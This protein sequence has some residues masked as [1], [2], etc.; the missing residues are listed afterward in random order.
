MMAEDGRN[1]GGQRGLDSQDTLID[2]PAPPEEHGG[3]SPERPGWF[4]SQRIVVTPTLILLNIAVFALMVVR[5]VALVEPA[6]SDVLPFGANFGPASLS[7]EPWR[8]LTAAFVHGGVVPFL[9]NVFCVL[10]VGW[11]TETLFG[12]AALAAIYLLSVLG[13]SLASLFW[14]PLAIAAGASGA[15]GGLWGALQAVAVVRYRQFPSRIVLAISALSAV[16]IASIVFDLNGEFADDAAHVGG[17]V[18]GFVA[19]ALVTRDLVRPEK[20]SARR[21]LRLVAVVV[22]L[23]GLAWAARTRMDHELAASVLALTP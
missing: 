18:T 15:V 10:I 9:V 16:L 13:S 20:A 8:I 5:G 4:P 14:H 22:V 17:L 7:G 11:L 12:S 23:L 6:G 21:L 3:F 19:G 2:R 1:V